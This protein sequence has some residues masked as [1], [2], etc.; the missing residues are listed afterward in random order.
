MVKQ[1]SPMLHICSTQQIFNSFYCYSYYFPALTLLFFKILISLRTLLSS[2]T[3]CYLRL[4]S[5]TPSVFHTCMT[6]YGLTC[7]PNSLK[8]QIYTFRLGPLLI[9]KYLRSKLLTFECLTGASNSLPLSSDL[10]LCSY[11]I[12]GK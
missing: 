8:T 10:F 2:H 11:F 5:F 12:F 3:V 7:I 6:L 9:S 4:I 1:A